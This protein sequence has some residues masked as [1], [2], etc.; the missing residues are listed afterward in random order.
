[1]PASGKTRTGS[2][3]FRSVIL[4]SP[5]FHM[6]VVIVIIIIVALTLTTSREKLCRFWLLSF[7]PI[8]S[9]NGKPL[10]AKHLAGDSFF[11]S[12]LYI[13]FSSSFF[14]CEWMSFRWC[15]F[16]KL[17]LYSIRFISFFQSLMGVVSKDFLSIFEWKTCFS[18]IIVWKD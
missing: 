9:L 2:N 1:M 17:C 18:L 4:N 5:S 6:I 15:G 14:Y 16:K 8:T 11:S 7:I 13:L 12:H 3:I 10:C